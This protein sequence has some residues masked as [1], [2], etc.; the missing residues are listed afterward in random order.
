MPTPRH[1]LLTWGGP[2]QETNRIERSYR[3]WAL[4]AVLLVMF[5]A[6]ISGTVVSTAVPTIVADLHGFELYGW[7]FTGYMLASTVTVPIF[8]KLSDLYGRRPLYLVGIAFFAAGMLL[9]AVA[10]TML[11]LIVA[12]IVAGIGGGAMMALST[13]SI[14]DIFSPRER[15][16]WM[17]V[18]MGV[19][20]LS[21]IV[22]PTLGGAITDSLGWRWVFVVPVPVA[23][24]AW[25][26]VGIV[27][28]RVRAQARVPLD[29]AGA[30]LMIAGLVALLLGFT[31]GGTSYP[32]VSWQIGVCFVAG[33][34]LLVSFVRHEHRAPEPLLDPALFSNRVFALS[35]AISFLVVA[36]MY[37][38]L[39]FIP[40]FVQGVVG[41]SAQNSGVVLT[42]MMLA[43]VVGSTLGG[44]A[45]SRTGRYKAQAIVGS[46]VMLAGF[47]LFSTLSAGSGSG[48]VIRD[49]VVLGL[50]IGM[51][52]P[53]FSMTV[54][55]AFPHRL[56]GTVNSGRQLFSNLGGAVAVPVMT[57]II[58]NTFSRELPGRAPAQLRPQLSGHALS[59]QSLLTPQAQ[60]AI[61]HRFPAGA[62]GD[63]LYGQFVS[64]V[65]HSLADGIV[66]IFYVGAALAAIAFL[67][68]IVFPRI[69]LAS[70][71]Q[72]PEPREP[73]A[74]AAGVVGTL[75]EGDRT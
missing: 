8:G 61:R 72:P 13:A 63:R 73:F 47:C 48:E 75:V 49:M 46:A 32:W 56:L 37:G 64:A 16:R 42:P 74:E 10:T 52:M 69:E 15:G 67:L 5:T 39:S 18:V 11:F 34:G 54:Q 41:V 27:M 35:V 40:L 59:P 38:S 70:W 4:A 51:T 55:S 22:G 44:Q 43:F 62:A 19:F 31:W 7:V 20:G 45:I 60:A 58:V 14:G 30:S 36:G 21:S 23:A 9:S 12:R 6:S 68:T 25:T 57:A 26:I 71:E 1:H 33:A 24:L 28:P 65:R 3:W 50:G 17:G 53:I 66:R 29:V 2:A